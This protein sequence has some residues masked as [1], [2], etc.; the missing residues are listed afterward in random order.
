MGMAIGAPAITNFRGRPRRRHRSHGAGRRR[1]RPNSAQA[2]SEDR[3]RR[4]SQAPT[5]CFVD[6]PERDTPQL[7]LDVLRPAAIRRSRFDMTARDVRPPRRVENAPILDRHTVGLIAAS[8]PGVP[9]RKGG[10]L[11]RPASSS[12]APSTSSTWWRPPTPSNLQRPRTRLL[13][14]T[15]TRLRLT[16]PSPARR[17]ACDDHQH[18]VHGPGD[19]RGQAGRHGDR[20]GVLQL[21]AQAHRQRRD[22]LHAAI[23]P[24]S[25]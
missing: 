4:R 22:P 16:R 15:S 6:D 25:G 13:D 8:A 7:R 10:V 24:P 3:L 19:R 18:P 5:S 9:L 20:R 23:S 17:S 21:G 2:V 1:A 11:L 12:P 14:A